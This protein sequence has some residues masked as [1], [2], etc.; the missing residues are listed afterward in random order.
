MPEFVIERRSPH[1]IAYLMEFDG[2][3]K[4]WVDQVNLAYKFGNSDEAY[5]AMNYLFK[6][7]SLH[8][9]KEVYHD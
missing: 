5:I 8:R 3:L 1:S 9:V 4:C 2:E 7:D 6:Y